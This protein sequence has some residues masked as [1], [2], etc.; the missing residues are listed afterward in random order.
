MTTSGRQDLLDVIRRL[1]HGKNAAYR[2]AWK[3]RGELIS[4]LANIARKVDRL[5]YVVDGGPTTVDEPVWD[6]AVD[7][8]VYALKYQTY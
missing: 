7:L 6:T 8:L 4:I 5:E 2:D 3:K 1:H